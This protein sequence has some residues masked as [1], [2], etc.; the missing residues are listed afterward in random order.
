[1]YPCPAFKLEL[2]FRKQKPCFGMRKCL[3]R[4]N[5][6]RAF[7]VS[8][9]LVLLRMPTIWF[10]IIWGSG[11]GCCLERL[12][13]LATLTQS[14]TE[15]RSHTIWYGLEIVKH[16]LSGWVWAKYPFDSIYMNSCLRSVW[17]S[18]TLD[19]EVCECGNYMTWLVL[20]ALLQQCNVWYGSMSHL[21]DGK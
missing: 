1:M 12:D 2:D 16:F 21:M 20:S 7:A 13:K 8:V 14:S 11:L 17:G 15:P 9:K 10:W 3:Y 5:F 18:H 19:T 4:I 6:C